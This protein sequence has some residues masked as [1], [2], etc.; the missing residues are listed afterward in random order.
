MAYVLHTSRDYKNLPGFQY[1]ISV[2]QL[3]VQRAVDNEK[4]LIRVRVRVP[5]EFTE[6]LSELDL[7]VVES[8]DCTLGPMV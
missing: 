2:P 7:V 5:N 4:Q 8:A 3:N 6:Q 1:D